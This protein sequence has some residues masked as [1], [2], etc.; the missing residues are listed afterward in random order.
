ME[1]NLT[2]IDNMYEDDGMANLVGFIGG[3]SLDPPGPEKR[4]LVAVLF[5]YRNGRLDRADCLT[6]RA[7]DDLSKLE[8]EEQDL[9]LAKA[10]IVA[11]RKADHDAAVAKLNAE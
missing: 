2:S 4:E 6:V 5:E 9:L 3:V 11:R 10:L 1:M 7:G 8:P